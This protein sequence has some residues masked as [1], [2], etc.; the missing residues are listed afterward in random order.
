[1][2]EQQLMKT[3]FNNIFNFDYL[4]V[5]SFSMIERAE[6]GTFHIFVL[7]IYSLIKAPFNPWLGMITMRDIEWRFLCRFTK[8]Q[9]Q[10]LISISEIQE[11]LIDQE[12]IKKTYNLFMYCIFIDYIEHI[13][14]VFYWIFSVLYILCISEYETIKSVINS[15]KSFQHF[16]IYFHIF[17]F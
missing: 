5:I 17:R 16:K 8:D 6:L 7:V 3:R 13:G 10:C 12:K 15:V 14:I 2:S 4:E 11:F 1:M 9:N